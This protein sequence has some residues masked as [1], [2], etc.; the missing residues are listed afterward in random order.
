MTDMSA[1][2]TLR[3]YRKFTR[4]P[5]GKWLFSRAVCLQAPYFG[6]ISPAS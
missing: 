3:L 4:Y 2:R 1:S 6:S 5:M